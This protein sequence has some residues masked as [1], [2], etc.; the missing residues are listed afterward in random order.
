MKTQSLPSSGFMAPPTSTPISFKP[1]HERSN[2]EPVDKHLLTASEDLD[3]M[4][5]S[6]GDMMDS[7]FVPGSLPTTS[8]LTKN[9]MSFN[10]NN[11]NNKPK[12]GIAALLSEQQQ[13]Q[14][15]QQPSSLPS[16]TFSTTNYNTPQN[17]VPSEASSTN[18]INIS[19]KNYNMSSAASSI[20]STGSSFGKYSSSSSPPFGYAGGS[21]PNKSFKFS[22]SPLIDPLNS[23]TP[24][25]MLSS[26]LKNN[27]QQSPSL[28]GSRLADR[29]TDNI[30]AFFQSTK[31]TN[32]PPTLNNNN[33]RL[34]SDL[35]FDAHHQTNSY[36]DF[37]PSFLQLDEDKSAGSLLSNHSNEPPFPYKNSPSDDFPDD[38]DYYNED[39][40]VM[41]GLTFAGSGSGASWKMFDA[42]HSNNPDDDDDQEDRIS[43]FMQQLDR[44]P[45]R[46]KTLTS[47]H[48]RTLDQLAFEL[49]R[50]KNNF[51]N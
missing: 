11:T 12:G 33:V 16:C 41:D 22:F 7:P 15:H 50:I 48:A 6:I 25:S 35:H 44:A 4:S 30:P 43:M 36:M 18:P 14:L 40:I 1:V 39:D 24:P 38:V 49:N 10:N 20:G 26:S 27:N 37:P 23:Y 19:R 28:S 2:T 21:F 29:S 32:T 34:E 47:S 9:I 17:S 45:N 46:L 3:L 51:K 8:N 42:D 13:Q 31:T 5:A